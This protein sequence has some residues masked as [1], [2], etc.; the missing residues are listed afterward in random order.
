[1]C[2]SSSRLPSPLRFFF[3]FFLLR[4]VRFRFYQ[5]HSDMQWAVENFYIGPACEGHCGGH[6]DCLDQRCLCDP[7]FTGPNCYASSALKVNHSSPFIYWPSPEPSVGYMFFTW[8][9]TKTSILY[10][11]RFII[12]IIV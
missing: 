2:R 12:D 9:A 4:A 5:Q 1:V 11:R 3:F 7:G 6:G 10:Y 8:P